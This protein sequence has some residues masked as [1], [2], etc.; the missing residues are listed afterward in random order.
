[1][2]VIAEQREC[3]QNINREARHTELFVQIDSR[4]TPQRLLKTKII[5]H[6]VRQEEPEEIRRRA[7]RVE[8]GHQNEWRR[9]VKDET[10]PAFQ[11]HQSKLQITDSLHQ[12]EAAAE[13]H[14]LASQ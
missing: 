12:G 7:D 6:Q 14:A 5:E 4:I 3:R 13:R 1:M 10:L 2:R 8:S 9:E 11:V